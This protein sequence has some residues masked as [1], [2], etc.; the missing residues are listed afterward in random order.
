[1]VFQYILPLLLITGEVISQDVVIRIHFHF[2]DLIIRLNGSGLGCPFQPFQYRENEC[3]SK[4]AG[5]NQERPE[6]PELDFIP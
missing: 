1:M 6:E 2:S 4:E 5:D 3:G